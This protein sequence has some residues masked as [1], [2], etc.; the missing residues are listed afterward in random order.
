[1]VTLHAPERP[2]P[3]P[4]PQRAVRVLL[5][6]RDPAAVAIRAL[7]V[8]SVV[9]LAWPVLALVVG[10]FHDT[11]PGETARWGLGA[12]TRAFDNPNMWTAVLNTVVFTAVVVPVS[13]AVGLT[14]ALI[15]TCSNVRLRRLIGP[16]VV[17]AYAMPPMFYA[18]G[19]ALAGSG[20]SGLV[21]DLV[22][23]VAGL[24]PVLNA[25]S[26]PGL[27]F[28][29]IMRAGAYSY[30]L[31]AGPVRALSRSQD[32]AVQASGGRSLSDRLRVGILPSLRPALAGALIL[33]LI[34]HIGLFDAVYILGNAVGITTIS[35]LSYQLLQTEGTPDFA[36]A[37]V[38][39][40]LILV[41]AVVLVVVQQRRFDVRASV[42]V[43]G[44]PE[45]ALALDFSPI[46]R[47]VLDLLIAVYVVVF[48]VVPVG[49]I[50]LTS[51]Q[52]FPGLYTGL[53][54]KY[55]SAL[56]ASPDA[57][58][59]LLTTFVLGCLGSFVGVAFALAIVA[60]RVTRPGAIST[61]IVA[62]CA[63][64]PVALSGI[65]GALGYIWSVVLFEPTKG[66]YGS[67]LLLV[68]ALSAGV[69]P[70]AV[71][72][73]TGSIT[74]ID[75]GLL[76]SARASGDSWLRA[77]VTMVVPVMAPSLVNTWFLSFI[78]VAGA[79]DLTLIL[80]GPYIQPASTFIYRA[81]ANAS[82]GQATAMLVLLLVGLVVLRGLLQVVTW[83]LRPDLNPRRRKA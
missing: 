27:L 59:A 28:V 30:I 45:R 13:V 58:N 15:G 24:D 12:F 29:S 39:G 74:Q 18:I 10:A 11:P 69:V 7:A 9:V 35:V 70:A 17:V 56:F 51:V 25:T 73:L 54:G 75:P 36:A 68:V 71:M 5:G 22:R 46:G 19:Y 41:L 38:T 77:Y 62:A 47:I 60:A 52:R 43:S 64:A 65:V 63:M 16:T 42:T 20:R 40:L 55:Y 82:F 79:L 23:T 66:L 21:N 50:L 31:L 49:S 80:S 48:L 83:L 37:S 1:M 78:S 4:P 6:V 53:T 61:S 3:T 2:A 26:W 8:V 67:F 33:A 32:E 81:Y 57:T 14:L 34:S 76:A 44:K 72:L